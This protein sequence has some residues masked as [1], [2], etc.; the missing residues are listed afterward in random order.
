MNFEESFKSSIKALK[1]NKIRSFLTMLGIVIGLP[2]FLLS[3][4]ES[5][6]KA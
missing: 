2:L 1:G 4:I 3:A 6:E 5:R